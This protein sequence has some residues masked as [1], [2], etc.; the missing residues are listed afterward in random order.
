M[1]WR[2]KAFIQNQLVRLPPGPSQA[3]YY[4]MQRAMGSFRHPQAGLFLEAAQS[5]RRHL[6]RHGFTIEGAT[7]LEVG[8]GRRLTLPVSLWLMG[9]NRIITVDLHRYLKQSIVKLDLHELVASLTPPGVAANQGIKP[10]RLQLLREMLQGPMDLAKFEQLC[11]IEYHAPA[12]AAHLK[13]PDASIDC[14]I[15]YTV[16]EHIP[17]PV[18]TDILSEARRVLRPSGLAIHLIDHSDHFAH[19]DT[20]ISAINFL[21]YDDAAWSRLADNPYMYMNRLRADDYPVLYAKAGH[22]ILSMASTPEPIL[23]AQL[24]SPGF[25]LAKRFQGKDPATLILTSSW[26]VSRPLQY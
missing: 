9:A 21:Q 11:G 3:C 18:L 24:A 17:P 14:H 15:S 12:N 7:V 22:E 6:T 10:E 20:S 19:S 13:L 16:F 4:A 8:T 25:S 5:Y 23:A 26:V 1:N 2:I